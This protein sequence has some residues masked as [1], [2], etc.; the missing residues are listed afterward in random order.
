MASSLQDPSAVGNEDNRSNPLKPD[1]STDDNSRNSFD[2]DRPSSSIYKESSEDNFTSRYDINK[3]INGLQRHLKKIVISTLIFFLLGSLAAYTFL[4]TYVADAVVV[5]Q[6]DK[7]VVLVGGG[8][9]PI[10]TL[11]TVID[12]IQLPVNFEAIKKNLGLSYSTGELEGMVSVPVPK[13]NSNLI[14]ITAKAKNQYLAVDLANA[15]AQTAVKSAQEYYQKQLQP[16]LL[17]YSDQLINVDQRLNSQLNEIGRFKEENNYF[18]MTAEHSQFIT[19]MNDARTKLEN[20]KILYSSLLVEYD[21]LKNTIENLPDQ[22]L[23]PQS[24]YR[25]G[26]VNPLQT[27]IIALQNSLSEARLKFAKDNPRL[28]ALESELDNLVGQLKVQPENEDKQI[29]FLTK[30]ESKDK[31]QIEL[32]QLEGK[33]KSAKQTQDDL[34]VVYAG[35][36]KEMVNLPAKQMAFAKLLQARQST[37]DELK[38]LTS[39]VETTQLMMNIPQGSLELYSLAQSADPWKNSLFIYLLPLLSALFGALLGIGIAFFF[40]MQDDKFSTAR[41]IESAYKMTC[42]GVIPRISSLTKENAEGK[43]LFFIRGIA[44]RLEKIISKSVP[45]KNALTFGIT[46]SVNEEGKSLIAENLA[47]YYKRL[48]KKVLLIQTAHRAGVILNAPPK[49]TLDSY[50]KNPGSLTDLIIHDKVDCIK[51]GLK[52]EAGMKELVKSKAMSVLWNHLQNQY[53][54]IILD[55]PGILEEDYSLNLLDLPPYVIY[56]VDSEKTGKKIIDEALTQ[57]HLHDIK[58]CGVI[59]NDVDPIFIDDRRI[60]NE[61]NVSKKSYWEHLSQKSFW[62]QFMFWKK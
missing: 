14:H 9:L 26:Q 15:L 21:S 44:G 36:Q 1:K 3:L 16:A 37:E 7:S 8:T 20:A 54:I 52:R 12:L 42:I 23:V 24:L 47:L 6:E 4:T 33:V 48:E 32:L 28:K 50:L 39:A 62:E 41:Q 34:A 51:I 17:N 27:R 55:T 49:I 30:N 19:R 56:V 46:S 60:L 59:L 18:E 45:G 43:L 57:L 31:L 40:E 29:R 38:S 2:Q 58:P 53:E 5:Y 11:P 61:I 35:Y 25:E 13:N 10:L 22:I